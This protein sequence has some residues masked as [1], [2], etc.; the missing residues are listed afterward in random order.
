MKANYIL[1]ETITPL[2]K[3]RTDTRTDDYY[4]ESTPD[5]LMFVARDSVADYI[6]GDFL[7]TGSTIGLYGYDYSRMLKCREYISGEFAR[8][9]LRAPRILVAGDEAENFDFGINIGYCLRKN[10]SGN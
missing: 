9:G 5:D 4:T 7:R 10:K 3:G 6:S 1:M 2:K 8:R